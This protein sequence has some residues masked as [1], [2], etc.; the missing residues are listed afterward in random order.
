MKTPEVK[1]LE[2]IPFEWGKA[3]DRL[4]TLI[5]VWVDA[6]QWIIVFA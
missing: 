1:V 2:C 6:K 3:P 5:L 4:N